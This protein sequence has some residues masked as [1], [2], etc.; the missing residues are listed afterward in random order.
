MDHQYNRY[1]RK[2]NPTPRSEASSLLLKSFI[3]SLSLFAEIIPESLHHF[4]PYS[5]YSDLLLGVGY[6]A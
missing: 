1:R 4:R 6:P 3:L 5:R 2:V